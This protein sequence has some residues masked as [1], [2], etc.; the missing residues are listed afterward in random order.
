MS[1]IPR[2][3]TAKRGAQLCDVSEATLRQWVHRGYL[4]PV[5]QYRDGRTLT[6]W[7]LLRHVLD[8]AAERTSTADRTEITQIWAAVD[9]GLASAQVKCHSVA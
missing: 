4:A 1:A 2:L 6:N 7:Y 8:C 5:A 9:E 3:V